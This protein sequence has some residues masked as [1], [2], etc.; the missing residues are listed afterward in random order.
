MNLVRAK[1]DPATSIHARE[2]TRGGASLP[3][4]LAITAGFATL[5][6]GGIK[7]VEASR[8]TKQPLRI[9]GQAAGMAFFAYGFYYAASIS[10]I[11]VL[12]ALAPH[13][14]PA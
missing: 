6:Y 1:R 10:L 14:R 12:Q 4:K 11:V 3:V 7:L 2:A 8:R 5:A 13:G 9:A